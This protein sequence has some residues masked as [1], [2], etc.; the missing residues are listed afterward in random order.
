MEILSLLSNPWLACLVI[1]IGFYLL[2][3]GAD[4][5]VSG[6]SAVARQM[7]VSP[8]VI[9]LT[10][11]AFGTSMPEFIVSAIA[12]IEGNTEIA[13]TNILGSNSINTCIIL[14]LSALIYPVASQK[15]SR[16]FDIPFSVL[17]GLLV[18]LFATYTRP[19]VFRWGNWGAFSFQ[20]GFISGV[21]GAFLLL[22][23]IVFMWH[24][25][26][27]AKGNLDKQAEDTVSISRTRAY[28]LI[29]IGLV[30]L[31][32][33]GEM[34]VRSA[35]SIAHQLGVSDAIIGLTI[36]ALGT[37]LPE[38]ATSCV[39]AY[40]HNSDLAIGNVIGSNIFN[41]FF[42][43]GTSA[44]IHPLPVYP[45]LWLDAAIVTLSSMLV[46]LF[47]YSN[48]EHKIQRGH[49]AVLLLLYAI[50]LTYRIVIA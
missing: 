45:G 31:V 6:A 21:G 30:G 27:Y 9:G 16:K 26:H 49:G 36:V 41:V 22:C 19:L 32:L 34:I 7:G 37:S 10:V 47:V 12:A 33:G 42:I 18:L 29:L 46:M 50:Y 4:W 14:G 23:F 40:R 24:S 44:L 38:L 39:A 15:S 3:K 48:K 25:V 5:L 13:I 2:V 20:C 28:L 8:L 17:A 11:V 1:V 35:T 43:L